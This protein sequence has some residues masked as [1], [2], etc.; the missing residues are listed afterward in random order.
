[1][2]NKTA[3]LLDS[4]SEGVYDA[5]IVMYISSSMPGMAETFSAIQPNSPSS[6]SDAL[7]INSIL[8]CD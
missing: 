7:L 5:A 8:E 4:H 6:K 3:L 1:M 2:V